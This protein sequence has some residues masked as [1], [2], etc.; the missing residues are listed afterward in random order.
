[1][2]DLLAEHPFSS[3][4]AVI[5][6]DDGPL[7]LGSL[8]TRVA[9]LAET[10]HTAGVGPGQAVANLVTPGPSSVVVMFAVWAVGAVYVPVNVRYAAAEVDDLVAETAGRPARPAGPSRC[11]C[12]T[13]A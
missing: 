12:G 13:A 2:S 9:A 11:C 8:R 3:S 4:E 7:T 10:L 6:S 1:M 5:E